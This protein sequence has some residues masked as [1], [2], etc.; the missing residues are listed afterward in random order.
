M[1]LGL[2][3]KVALVAAASRG[4]G[5]AIALELATEGAKIVMCARVRESLESARDMIVS[6][7]GAE[8]HAV[9]ADVSNREHIELVTGEAMRK[10]G[11]VDVLITNAGGPPPGTFDSH[12][13]EVWERAVNLTLR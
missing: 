11:H 3:G 7:T 8:V 9:V 13:W 5:R 6:S 1:D 10:F 2:K 12:S 4:L